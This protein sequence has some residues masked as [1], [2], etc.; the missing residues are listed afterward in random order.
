M[1][2]AVTLLA[3]ALLASAGCDQLFTLQHL[4][5]PIDAPEADALPSCEDPTPFGSECRTV[6]LPVT[7]DTFI[8]ATE[9][10]AAFGTRDAMRIS[11][12]DPA[13]LKFDTSLIAPGERIAA[14]TLALDPKYNQSAKTC[15]TDN[16][17]CELCPS[18]GFGA[19]ELRWM[20]TS[21]NEAQATWNL[22][23]GAGT[24]WTTPGAAA[25][26]DDRS[27]RVATGAPPV[28]GGSLILTVTADQLHA[29]SPDCY[30]TENQLALLVTIEGI[31]YFD[32]REGSACITGAPPQLTVTLCRDSL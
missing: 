31:A 6:M 10:D 9:P 8:T 32:V 23:A 22:P 24:S 20:R 15:S 2:R 13:L 3:L 17:T 30:R 7:N 5:P 18:P 29:R 12:T 4:G 11:S 27:E 26:P 28:G 1:R 21:W 16:Q 19:W 25:V 14:M